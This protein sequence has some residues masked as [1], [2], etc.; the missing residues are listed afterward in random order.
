MTRVRFVVALSSWQATRLLLDRDDAAGDA[1]ALPPTVTCAPFSVASSSAGESER[2]LVERQVLEGLGQ[3]FAA[4]Q[5]QSADAALVVVDDQA[6]QHVVDLFERD[7]EL[8]GG[9]AVDR[10]L[11][12]EVAEA[13][14][15]QHHALER[16]VLG[17]GEVGKREQAQQ[18]HDGQQDSA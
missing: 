18:S 3:R 1:R 10:G 5:A 15:R 8:Q 9:V 4:R 11:V 12:L 6:L 13:A 7:G 2:V 17:K 14:G 16:E